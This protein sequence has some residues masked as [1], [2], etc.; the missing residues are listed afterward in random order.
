MAN[1]LIYAPSGGGKTVNATRVPI[2][3]RGK[4]LLL[5]SD[6]SQVVL[7]NFD[8]K[9]WIIHAIKD[10]ADLHEQFE[11]AVSAELYDNI[12]LDNLSD[13]FD[14][15]ILELEESGKYKDMRQ[16][17]QLVYQS[18]KRL[19]RKAGQVNTNVTFTAWEDQSEIVL[20][21]GEK[22]L[23]ISPKLPYKIL[24]SVCGLCNIVG[25]VRTKEKDGQK[26]WY[27]YLE[28]SPILYAKDQLH[29]RK[30][31]LPEEL[32]EITKKEK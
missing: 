4:N 21:T 18:I 2:G 28:G 17:Y 31:C 8:R 6:N 10:V 3:K 23:R 27:Y 12:V 32:F 13:I 19:T 29:C 25:Y 11:Q 24:D 5:C 1:A 16:A 15:W 20:P 7:N 22:A 30:F 9:G 26:T 14:L